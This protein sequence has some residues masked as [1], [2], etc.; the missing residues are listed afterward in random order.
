MEPGEYRELARGL[1]LEGLTVDHQREVVWYSDVIAGGMHAVTFDGERVGS[2]DHDRMWTGGAMMN[3]DG[4]VLST[5]QSG[6]RWNHPETG[7]SGWLLRELEG[8]PINGIN[9]MW[10]DGT[11]GIFFG[12]LDIE[13]IIEGKDTRPVR[14]YR[15]TTDGEAIRLAD[16]LRF[17]N[18]I[19]FDPD[20]RRLYCNATFECTWVFDVADDLT[21][22]N[23]RLLLDIEDADGMTL[24]TGGNVWITGFR[25]SHLIRI[26]PDGSRLPPV[27][28]PPGSITQVRFGG[29]DGCDVFINT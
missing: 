23:R 9:E 11:G 20:R 12:T 27:P 14:L 28:T 25:T 26:A 4:A 1:Y 8:E 17:T 6:I 29:A 13:R 5:G 22:S 7:R 19:A 15:L 2:F 10:P 24:D 18:G 21:L 16:N 3:A